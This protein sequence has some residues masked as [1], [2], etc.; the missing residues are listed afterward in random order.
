MR[1]SKISPPQLTHPQKLFMYALTCLNLRLRMMAGVLYENMILQ[2]VPVANV[3]VP[4]ADDAVC[5]KHEHVETRG[6]RMLRR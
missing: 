5:G 6:T 2:A 4:V 1:K 3:T